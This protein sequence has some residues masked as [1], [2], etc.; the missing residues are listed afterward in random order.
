MKQIME[1]GPI[2]AGEERVGRARYRASAIMRLCFWRGGE[3]EDSSRRLLQGFVR[4][5]LVGRGG[6]LCILAAAL[7]LR[8][9]RWL[10]IFSET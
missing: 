8:S 4:A 10:V 9:G 3:M 5:G 7:N 2:G 6:A 1:N